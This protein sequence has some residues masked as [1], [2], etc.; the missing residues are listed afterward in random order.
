M[1][2]SAH[3]SEIHQPTLVGHIIIKVAFILFWNRMAMFLYH[4]FFM[5]GGLIL[6]PDQIKAES[7]S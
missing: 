4:K 6:S 7:I 1:T 5:E 3:T 2:W